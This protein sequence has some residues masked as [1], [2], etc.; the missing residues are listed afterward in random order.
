MK[1]KVDFER[2][3]E[4]E[5]IAT[6]PSGHQHA[7][8]GWVQVE[9]PFCTGNPG[10]H[11]GFNIDDNYF[12]CWRCGYKN[13]LDVLKKLLNISSAD[14]FK[15]LK[16]YSSKRSTHKNKVS[17]EQENKSLKLP[18]GTGVLKKMHKRYLKGR[19]FNPN[20]LQ[21]IW[22]I[23]G[24]GVVGPFCYR[25][26]IPIYFKGKLI[27]YQGRDIS[28]RAKLRYKNCPIDQE[29]KHL[30]NIVYGFDN[31]P[32]KTVVI[33]E[34]VTDVWKLGPGAVATFGTGYTPEQVKLLGKNFDR[35]Y[36]LYDQDAAGK[37]QSKKLAYKLAMYEGHTSVIKLTGFKGK[38]PGELSN[39]KAKQIMETLLNE[40]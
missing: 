31:V 14:L 38:D 6:A 13:T 16:D 8:D 22:G 39:K 29:V 23:M 36:I 4:D 5:G 18:P 3:S 19:G 27:S 17:I 2:L 21:L 30:K 26:V 7:R 28:D 20:E 33:C 1:I 34:G 9:C 11:L 15:K 12:N 37:S 24:T 40:N 35:R 25:L 10:Y 32:G